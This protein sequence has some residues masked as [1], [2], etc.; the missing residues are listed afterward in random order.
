MAIGR[1]EVISSVLVIKPVLSLCW[2]WR[3]RGGVS[4][5][6]K[7]IISKLYPNESFWDHGGL[8]DGEIVL[9]DPWRSKLRLQVVEELSF[10][11]TDLPAK[12]KS[13]G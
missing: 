2:E 8:G 1:L 13:H 5:D 7:F 3:R 6:G 10:R 9:V 4:P 12:P 11:L